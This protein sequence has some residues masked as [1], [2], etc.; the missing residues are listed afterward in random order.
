M[1]IFHQNA[2]KSTSNMK[3]FGYKTMQLWSV[4]FY[5]NKWLSD[6]QATYRLIFH[7]WAWDTP[8]QLALINCARF[9][10]SLDWQLVLEQQ[11]TITWQTTRRVHVLSLSIND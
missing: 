9:N 3:K 5:R 7:R 10:Q 11:E 1:P 2:I 8:V 6:W 4:A